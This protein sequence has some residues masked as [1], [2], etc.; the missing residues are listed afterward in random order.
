V[1]NGRRNPLHVDHHHR[2]WITA[3]GKSYPQELSTGSPVSRETRRGSV[4]HPVDSP[5]DEGLSIG[6]VSRETRRVKPSTGSTHRLW[7]VVLTYMP[8][9]RALSRELAN[10]TA[11]GEPSRRNGGAAASQPHV[12][13]PALCQRPWRRTAG[14]LAPASWPS[15]NLRCCRHSRSPRAVVALRAG[16]VGSRRNVSL[17]RH[18]HTKWRRVED[19]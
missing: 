3:Y 11:T 14:H 17:Y 8:C 2:L 19:R 16:E 9:T 12:C 6:D 1:D 15:S 7:I 18:A 13:Q 4:A 5:V 10:V